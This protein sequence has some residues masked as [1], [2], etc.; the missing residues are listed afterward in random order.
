MSILTL[1]S[2]EM[3]ASPRLIEDLPEYKRGDILISRITPCG[4]VNIFLDKFIKHANEDSK[5]KNMPKCS[6][7]VDSYQVTKDEDGDLQ[8]NIDIF[9]SYSDEAKIEM[10]KLFHHSLIQKG[11]EEA[12][13]LWREWLILIS[14]KGVW[15]ESTLNSKGRRG[16]T[17]YTVDDLKPYFKNGIDGNETHYL[18]SSKLVTAFVIKYAKSSSKNIYRDYLLDKLSNHSSKKPPRNLT[19]IKINKDN[20]AN[21]IISCYS[22]KMNKI[23]HKKNSLNESHFM[24]FP[25]HQSDGYLY[26]IVDLR[27]NKT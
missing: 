12:I 16:K 27:T 21:L 6:Y 26:M 8:F 22:S 3:I 1:I 15:L 24:V 14:Q 13:K 10:L 20:V 19:S 4:V 23:R 18:S 7:H 9:Q 11:D 17:L 2:D 5:L 25:D